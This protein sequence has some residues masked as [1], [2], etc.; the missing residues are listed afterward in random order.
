M[1]DL[2]F[3][4]GRGRVHC[5][6]DQ[7]WNGLVEVLA[8]SFG[9]HSPPP[10]FGVSLIELLWFPALVVFASGWLITRAIRLGVRKVR[11]IS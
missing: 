3:S 4:T 1:V 7:W 8:N 11:G 10:F 2:H 5:Y 9:A 6:G